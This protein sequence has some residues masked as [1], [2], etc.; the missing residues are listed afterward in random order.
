[1]TD[2]ILN[3]ESKTD[4]LQ[5][6]NERQ[7]NVS[8]ICTSHILK[9]LADLTGGYDYY[10]Q[11]KSNILSKNKSISKVKILPDG[12]IVCKTI[13]DYLQIWD[14]DGN[15]DIV[16]TL[17]PI[18]LRFIVTRKGNIITSTFEGDLIMWDPIENIIKIICRARDNEEPFTFLSFIEEISDIRIVVGILN[19]EIIFVINTKT[20]QI[21][22]Q[23]SHIDQMIVDDIVYSCKLISNISIENNPLE[24]QALLGNIVSENSNSLKV[25]NLDSGECTFN[26]AFDSEISIIKTLSAKGYPS[27]PGST[28]GYPAKPGSTKGYPAKPGSTE[29]Y[30]PDKGPCGRIIIGFYD[31]K[32]II[33]RPEIDSNNYVVDTVFEGHTEKITKFLILSSNPNFLVSV[34]RDCTLKVWDL[35]NKVEVMTLSDHTAL[36]SSIK[37]LPDGRVV[38]GSDDHT[39][40]IWNLMITDELKSEPNKRCEM[41]L[42]DTTNVL[43]IA[44]LPDGK[45]VSGTGDNWGGSMG[46]TMPDNGAL[47]IWS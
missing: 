25:W 14:Q 15:R 41:T 37:E 45:I 12:R 35:E 32:I 24:T 22:Q 28:K 8:D 43:S 27:K 9:D 38:S 42:K 2:L 29:G 18:P 20:C 47:S 16:R 44:V 46:K 4:R 19:E 40:K 34:S 36:I 7:Q 31:G 33:L 30:P 39:L 13:D 21:E 23:L 3:D 11:G 1:M 10:I 5:Q 17:G 6:S 26:L